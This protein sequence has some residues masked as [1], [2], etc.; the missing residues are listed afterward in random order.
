[1]ERHGKGA[2]K[3]HQFARAQHVDL[4]LCVENAENDSVDSQLLRSGDFAFHP[5]EFCGR[6]QEVS[7]TWADQDVKRNRDLAADLV[8]ELGAR[9]DALHREIS[10]KLH[11]MRA[12]SFG[13]DGGRDRLDA[14]FEQNRGRHTGSLPS[15]GQQA[16]DETN[17][18][19]SRHERSK[20]KFR[21]GPT[22]RSES[23]TES[24]AASHE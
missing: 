10:A 18:E 14:Y 3:L 1:M 15:A 11:T 23:T 22:R 19:R 4:L 5:F 9:G 6:E 17:D 20:R 21:S 16:S 2:G 24:R 8:D 7:R 13:C 12:P